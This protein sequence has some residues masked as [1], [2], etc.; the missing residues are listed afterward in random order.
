[1]VPLWTWTYLHGC[2]DFFVLGAE[3]RLTH[4]E[5]FWFP[6]RAACVSRLAVC[7]SDVEGPCTSRVL[8]PPPSPDDVCV[9]QCARIAHTGKNADDAVKTDNSYLFFLGTNIYKITRNQRILRTYCESN[10]ACSET[11]INCTHTFSRHL[12]LRPRKRT[13]KSMVVPVTP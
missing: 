3:P 8:H 6:A 10:G 9:S 1:M 11:G 12:R 5:V 2:C 4:I 13:G 7:L